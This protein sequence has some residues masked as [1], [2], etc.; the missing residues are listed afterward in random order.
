MDPSRLLQRMS[1][2]DAHSAAN[3]LAAN[4][5]VVFKLPD[6]LRDRQAFLQAL[7]GMK[8]PLDPPMTVVRSWDALLDSVRGGLQDLDAE[9][10]A[11]VWPDPSAMKLRAPDDLGGIMLILGDVAAHA[12]AW[13]KAGA[14]ADLRVV[15]GGDGLAEPSVP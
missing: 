2:E 13:A 4:G 12:P 15:V 10:V 8:F 11:I 1:S 5:W 14:P 9:R 6:D 7:V 3:Q